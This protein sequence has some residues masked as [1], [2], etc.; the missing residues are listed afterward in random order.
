[1][2]RKAG[3]AVGPDASDEQRERNIASHCDVFDRSTLRPR[4]HLPSAPPHDV[5]GF[6]TTYEMFLTGVTDGTWDEHMRWLM[7]ATTC[8]LEFDISQGIVRFPSWDPCMTYD[9]DVRSA[10]TDRVRMKGYSL[11]DALAEG[12]DGGAQDSSLGLQTSAAS[13]SNGSRFLLSF[14]LGQEGERKAGQRSSPTGT[15]R[16]EGSEESAVTLET[17]SSQDC[18]GSR[19]SVVSFPFSEG[20]E[21]GRRQALQWEEKARKRS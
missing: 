7:D 4:K 1:M 18:Q 6:R 12:R 17:D 15:A 11:S 3:D 13:P 16:S 5:E 21:E 14:F 2:G 10:V 9:F 19:S 20:Q 8:K